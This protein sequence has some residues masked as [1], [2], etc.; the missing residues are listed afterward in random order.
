MV[1]EE[2]YIENSNGV[3]QI[4]D[5][6]KGQVAMNF[7]GTN[8]LKLELL[9][10]DY[11][12]SIKLPKTTRNSQVFGYVDVFDVMCE[13]PNK[14]SKCMY[15]VNGVGVLS[16]DAVFI[17]DRVSENFE[18]RMV[19]DNVDIAIKMN[20]TKVSD[21]D[22]ELSLRRDT[23]AIKNQNY[24][25]YKFAT[26]WF[27]DMPR[28]YPLFTM[29]YILPFLNLNSIV[30]KIVNKF[31]YTLN[32]EG[33]KKDYYLPIV[34]KRKIPLVDGYYEEQEH[35]FTVTR[36]QTAS[37]SYSTSVSIPN[38]LGGAL[39]A[40]NV[41]YSKINGY[42][43]GTSYIVH[44]VYL[45]IKA[46]T[47]AKVVLR[48]SLTAATFD[49]NASDPTYRQQHIAIA[50]KSELLADDG[51]YSLD[52]IL[53]GDH[54]VQLNAGGVAEDFDVEM[55]VE[56]LVFVTLPIYNS[57]NG[58]S[59]VEATFQGSVRILPSY[60]DDEAYEGELI[61]V[62][63]S[64]PF[65]TCSD[66]FKCY[67]SAMGML[68]RLN[69]KKKTVTLVNIGT[70]LDFSRA[71]DWSK[72]FV[73]DRKSQ[74]VHFKSDFGQNNYIKLLENTAYVGGD[75]NAV[76]FTLDNKNAALEHDILTVNVV[77]TFDM[78][79]TGKIK[80]NAA[81]LTVYKF[82]YNDDGSTNVSK[83]DLGARI[84]MLESGKWGANVSSESSIYLDVMAKSVSVAAMTNDTYKPLFERMF[85][86]LRIV[87]ATFMLDEL[88][89]ANFDQLRPVYVE[90]FGA[91][92]F[93]NKISN[94]VAG[95]PCKVELIKL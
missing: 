53:F 59:G 24:S 31:G 77:P 91:H 58:A 20:D 15:Y 69:E 93:V 44:G 40:G 10:A 28:T 63:K 36:V 48:A 79:T 74:I 22:L 49:D 54:Y 7:Q 82:E 70:I 26:A 12:Q 8:L 83:E 51:N 4:V 32:Y 9:Y 78:E 1:T 64:I 50:K 11:S 16:D 35:R 55:D 94:W 86:K 41:P 46:R 37:T 34:P 5:L 62:E 87:E 13:F 89:I 57:A 18:G 65:D 72:K 81:E 39:N 42:H 25:W 2:L 47:P 75:L 14:R 92:F 21:L 90:Y 45:S 38:K 95:K 29:P 73:A 3:L 27:T 66:L 67:R 23:N 76:N 84:V 56:Y 19:V 68:V 17:L 52:K 71:L 88:D 61:D 80:Y 33:D 30:T 43:N 6:P 60:D 85:S